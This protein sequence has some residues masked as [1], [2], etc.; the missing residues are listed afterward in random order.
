MYL[1]F[2]ECQTRCDMSGKELGKNLMRLKNMLEA[3]PRYS[4]STITGP[5]IVT[6]KTAYDQIYL[7]EYM[8]TGSDALSAIT[9]HP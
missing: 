6:M 2:I 9:W 5:D 3:F 7:Q 1:S 4:K 8:S